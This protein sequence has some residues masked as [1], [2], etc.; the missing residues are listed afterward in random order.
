MDL[1]ENALQSTQKNRF[2]LEDGR[3]HCL[4]AI[5]KVDKFEKKKTYFFLKMQKAVKNAVLV[6]TVGEN[7]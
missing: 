5:S 4:Q 7:E 1:P 3:R 6:R 2:S